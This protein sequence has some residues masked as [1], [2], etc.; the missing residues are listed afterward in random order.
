MGLNAVNMFCRP[1]LIPVPTLSVSRTD[2]GLEKKKSRW[3]WGV[4]RGGVG[5][6]GYPKFPI[7]PCNVQGA[8]VASGTN[9]A[10]EMISSN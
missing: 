5:V 1:L 8:D 10:D 6:G 7:D 4:G 2:R 9:M 3:G